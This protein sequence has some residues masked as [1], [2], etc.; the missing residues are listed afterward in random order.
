MTAEDL[1]DHPLDSI[2]LNC[3]PVSARN[4]DPHACLLQSD[5][6][7]KLEVPSPPCSPLAKHAL[8]I[9]LFLEAYPRGKP[10]IIAVA[11]E[12]NYSQQSPPLQEHMPR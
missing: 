4:T 8:E 6:D 3:I 7:T 1:S 12:E 5:K 11:H 2:P 10:A 9:T